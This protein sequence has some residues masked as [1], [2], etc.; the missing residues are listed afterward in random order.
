MFINR[1]GSNGCVLITLFV[2]AFG[3]FSFATLRPTTPLARLVPGWFDTLKLRS[4]ITVGKSAC[5][6]L[7]E[8]WKFFGMP[9]SRVSSALV[10]CEPRGVAQVL[11]T[12]Q[13][14]ITLKHQI[15]ACI[16]EGRFPQRKD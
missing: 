16:R 1:D 10:L 4:F 14:F 3:S 11:A 8:V 15:A 13:E 5:V 6:A 7:A 9:G 2:R 12:V